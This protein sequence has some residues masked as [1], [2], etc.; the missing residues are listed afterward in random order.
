MLTLGW[1]DGTSFLPVNSVLLSSEHAQKR[2]NENPFLDKRSARYRQRKHSMKK[3]TEAVMDL[4]EAARSANI[5]AHYVLFDSWFLSPK[6]IHAVKGLGYDVIAMAKRSPKLKFS[7]QGR[8]L[9]LKESYSLNKK[10]RGRSRYLLSVMVEVN[11]DGQSVP[12]KVVYVRN[13]NKR[14]DYLCLISTNIETDENEIIRIY[15][16]WR[17]FS[18]SAKAVCVLQRNAVPCPMMQ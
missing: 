12:A 15:G 11:K 3:G 1:T 2:M 18:K 8:S 16:I 14:N 7:Y 13:K 9:S 5:P 4:L 10:R 17:C 6:T